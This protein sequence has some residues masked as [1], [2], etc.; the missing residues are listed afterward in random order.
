MHTLL[1]HY[2]QP[3]PIIQARHI[4]FATD[5]YLSLEDRCRILTALRLEGD[6]PA[7]SQIEQ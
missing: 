1:S 6:E 4:A 2:L 3:L 7:L 5:Q